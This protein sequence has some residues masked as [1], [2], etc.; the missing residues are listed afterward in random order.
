VEMLSRRIIE[1]DTVDCKPSSTTI[2]TIEEEDHFAK[3]H[4][5]MSDMELN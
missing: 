5:T 3:Y 2:L 1:G 4:V